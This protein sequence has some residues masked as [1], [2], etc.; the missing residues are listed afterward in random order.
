MSAT[1]TPGL[2]RLPTEIR[3]LIYDILFPKAEAFAPTRA[4]TYTPDPP[5]SV[6]LAI[7]LTCRQIYLDCRAIAYGRTTISL[8]VCAPLPP[9]AISQRKSSPSRINPHTPCLP[10]PHTSPAH[11]PSLLSF[12]TSV[13]L[14]P[15]ATED[16]IWPLESGSSARITGHWSERLPCVTRV[17]ICSGARWMVAPHD[18]LGAALAFPRARVIAAPAMRQYSLGVPGILGRELFFFRMRE[19]LRNEGLVEAGLEGEIRAQEDR[20]CLELRAGAAGE[21]PEFVRRWRHVQVLVETPVG[22][23]SRMARQWEGA[24]ALEE[25]GS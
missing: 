10:G 9:S 23:R 22:L 17:F 21:G 14:P 4:Y 11:A 24:C 15:R 12:A 3:W 18:V 7:L 25:K 5:L 8:P 20:L 16:L 2:L 1:S 6:R 19:L 13:A